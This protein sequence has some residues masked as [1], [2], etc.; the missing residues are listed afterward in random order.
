MTTKARI[1]LAVMALLSIAVVIPVVAYG[2]GAAQPRNERQ[3][4]ALVALGTG[5]TFQ[6]RLTDAGSPANGVYDF[7]FYLYDA[8]AG[9]AQV[10][11]VQTLGDVTVTAGLFTVTLNFGDVFHGSEYFLEIQ[12]RPGASSGTYTILTPREAISAVPNASFAREAASA[13][14]LQGVDVSVNAPAAGDVLKFDGVR[15]AP[16]AAGGGG[17][18][19]PFAATQ[20]LAG[21]LFKVTNTNTG[22]TASAIVAESGSTGFAAAALTGRI[23]S[24]S[25]GGFSAAVRGE[26]LGTG[27]NGIGVYGSQEGTG[28]G[29]YGEAPGGRGVYGASTT[30]TG[31]HGSSTSGNGGYFTSTSG[32]A[33]EVAGPIRVSGAKPAAFEWLATGGNIAGSDTVITNPAT[34]GNANAILIVTPLLGVA[35]PHP[36]AVYWDLSK[37]RIRNTDGA[38]MVSGSRYNI[39]VINQ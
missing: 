4:D 11:P 26:N 29:V 19:L 37:W 22:A 34:D 33:L 7:N 20:S 39:L 6:G 16:A 17:L 18:S 13:T 5:F 27:G 36:I 8:L 15:W 25:P 3:V 24:T 35:N 2:R 21:T 38:A 9:G 32:D 12:V 28:W 10:G 30:G 1:R 23:T 14:G 31:V